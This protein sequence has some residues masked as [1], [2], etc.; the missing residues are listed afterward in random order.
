MPQ[1]RLHLR[2]H[3]VPLLAIRVAAVCR[4]SCQLQFVPRMALARC[5]IR[6]SAQYVSGRSS[7]RRV[8][9]I[10]SPGVSVP[11]S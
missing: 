1:D 5:K 2:Q 8:R 7:P 4:A 9:Q 11:I 3:Q 6:R 10:G